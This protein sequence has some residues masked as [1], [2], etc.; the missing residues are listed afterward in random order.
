MK[1]LAINSSPLSSRRW[2]DRFALD[3]AMTL[4]GSGSKA[5]DLLVEYEF[6]ADDLVAF[7]QEP[8]FAQRVDH[9]RNQLKEKGFTFRL[10]AQAQAEML[11]DNSWDLIHT[12]DVSP[13]VKADLI[14]WTAK[15]AGYDTVKDG[16]AGDQGVKI[17]IFLG[18]PKEAPPAGMRTIEAS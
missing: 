16:A 14:K 11:L 3:L 18:D 6:T 2:T 15:V 10:K 9:F 17:N 12:P 7:G 5:E 1:E 13:A 8:L 4:E